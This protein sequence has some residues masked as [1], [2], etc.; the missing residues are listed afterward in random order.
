MKK[1]LFLILLLFLV[2]CSYDPYKMPKKVVKELNENS[3][4]I[5]EDHYST[6]LIKDSNVEIIGNDKLENDE[7]GT[8]KYTINYNN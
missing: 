5:Y 7:L 1:I 8:Y 6:E 4:N 3:F 2:G